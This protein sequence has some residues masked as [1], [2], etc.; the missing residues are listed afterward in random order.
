[1]GDHYNPA[2]STVAV[3]EQARVRE[4]VRRVRTLR[5]DHGLT[6]DQLGDIIEVARGE[7]RRWRS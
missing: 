4:T 3:R 1:M 6:D 2:V 7:Y 5:L